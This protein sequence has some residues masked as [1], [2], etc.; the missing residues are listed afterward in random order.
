MYTV[1][2]ILIPKY[3]KTDLMF[4]TTSLKYLRKVRVARVDENSTVAEVEIIEE[5]TGLVKATS[6]RIVTSMAKKDLTKSYGIGDMII[7]DL[8][9]FV[10]AISQ[11][12]FGN[13]RMDWRLKLI[14]INKTTIINPLK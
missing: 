1:D 11:I 13:W 10:P 8:K 9:Y 4:N 5:P 7:V 14:M 3:S 12:K 6:Q 2:E